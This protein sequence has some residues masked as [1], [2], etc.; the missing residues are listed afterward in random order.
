MRKELPKREMTKG[1]WAIVETK[2]FMKLRENSSTEELKKSKKPLKMADL[3]STKHIYGLGLIPRRT[4]SKSNRLKK[5]IFAI[6]KK[7]EKHLPFP[8]NRGVNY[9]CKNIRFKS[10]SSFHS[11]ELQ[12]IV[13]FLENN[14][15]EG[16]Y[17]VL[18]SE[19][20]NGS[21]IA[22]Q[23]MKT[24]IGDRIWAHYDPNHTEFNTFNRADAWVGIDHSYAPV[25]FNL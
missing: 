12:N 23:L 20:G 8:F 19:G 10:F 6:L 5:S 1:I 25:D 22:K 4:S 9:I 17:F 18:Y 2:T 16:K 13:S 15:T 11:E 24:S 14:L 7:I 3:S 21:R